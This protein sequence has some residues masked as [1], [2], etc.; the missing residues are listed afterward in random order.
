MSLGDTAAENDHAGAALDATRLPFV[1]LTVAGDC[2][3]S[4]VLGAHDATGLCS[5][6]L[7]HGAGV[8]RADEIQLYG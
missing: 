1:G 3:W 7:C 8:G 4:A 2:A 6:G 5:A